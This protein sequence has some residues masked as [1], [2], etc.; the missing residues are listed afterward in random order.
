VSL[1]FLVFPEH[2]SI[3]SKINRGMSR[4]FPQCSKG[5]SM[6]TKIKNP[7]EYSFVQWKNSP[8]TTGHW[9]DKARFYTFVKT[10][11]RYNARKWKSV[12]YLK[13]MIIKYLPDVELDFLENT[14]ADLLQHKLVI[15]V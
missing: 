12:D 6:L 10:V 7:V 11:C 1:V 14:L 9:A 13:K 8:H 5:D 3:K 4:F 15:W 2:E